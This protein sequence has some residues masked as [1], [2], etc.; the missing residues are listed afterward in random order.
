MTQVEWFLARKTP[1][2][3]LLPSV[4]STLANQESAALE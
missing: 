2:A 3:W 4:N 1:S